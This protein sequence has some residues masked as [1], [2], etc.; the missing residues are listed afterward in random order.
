MLG[1]GTHEATW[2]VF[3]FASF[4]AGPPYHDEGKTS[5]AEYETSI[6]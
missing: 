4:Y 3:D 2:K 1:G 5:V 6:E